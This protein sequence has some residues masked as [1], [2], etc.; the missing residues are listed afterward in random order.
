MQL[1]EGEQRRKLE[2]YLIVSPIVHFVKE[3]LRST[4]ILG[5]TITTLSHY[6]LKVFKG[7]SFFSTDSERTLKSLKDEGTDIISFNFTSVILT[8]INCI[9]L[10]VK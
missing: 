4:G 6:H 1:R 7:P 2:I 5:Q 3:K 8:N 10:L 9:I